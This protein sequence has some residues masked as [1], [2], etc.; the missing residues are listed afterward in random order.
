VF[1]FLTEPNDR[2]KYLGHMQEVLKIGGSAMVAT[3]DVSGPENCSGLPVQRYS[4]ESL[5]QELGDRFHLIESL[6]HLHHTPR[7]SS[8]PFRY[9]RFVRES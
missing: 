1:H 5:A 7:G 9:C 8:Q 2:V 6:L 4:A 3:F